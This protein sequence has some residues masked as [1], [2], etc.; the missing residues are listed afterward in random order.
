MSSLLVH[1]HGVDSVTPLIMIMYHHASTGMDKLSVGP[2]DSNYLIPAAFEK[3][4]TSPLLPPPP[5][6]TLPTSYNYPI[7][8][9]ENALLHVV[10]HIAR[11]L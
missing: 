4:P 5:S 3:N 7:L 11:T 1:V 9:T 10:I 2:T 6:I 8:A